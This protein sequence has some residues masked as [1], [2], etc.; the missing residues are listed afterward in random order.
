MM[1]LLITVVTL[2]VIA[3]LVALYFTLLRSLYPE[4]LRATEVVTITTRDV[5]RLRMCRY[6]RG[7]SSGEPILFVHGLG[8]NQHNFTAPVNAS[9][10]DYLVERGY[11]CW[12]LDLRGNRSSHPPFEYTRNDATLDGMLFY[13]LPAAIRHIRRTTGYGKVHYVGHSQGGMLLYAY[14]QLF[15]P[16]FI[17]SGTTLGSAVSMAPIKLRFPRLTQLTARYLAPVFG[18]LLRGGAPLV[19]RFHVTTPLFPINLRN[20]HPGVQTQDLYTM[21]EPPRARILE[22]YIKWARA[23]S[24]KM[25]SG[26]LDVQAGIPSMRF[27]LLA[28]L[29]HRDPIAPVGPGV[30]V[31]S[32]LP[33]ET[34]QILVLSKDNG[35]EE[36]YNHCDIP[37]GKNAPRELFDP[38]LRWLQTHPIQERVSLEEIDADTS[39]YLPPLAHTE[40]ASILSGAS[41]EHVT[42]DEPV[43]HI[44]SVSAP[45]EMEPDPEPM[46]MKVEVVSVEV[47]PPRPANK[48]A[49]RTTKAKSGLK[50]QTDA[51]AVQPQSAKRTAS[52]KKLP[53]KKLAAKPAAKKPAAKVAASAPKPAALKVPVKK[54]KALPAPERV[55]VPPA[56]K[57]ALS[58]AAAQLRNL[59]KLPKAKPAAAKKKP[60]AKGRAR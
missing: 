37:F 33:K 55:E 19:K 10:V 27:P 24:W 36:D 20:L 30:E 15:G 60:A 50:S 54:A 5:W 44:Q 38:I 3:F 40:R 25:N 58:N 34:T 17:A 8:V 45:L 9:I 23:K 29:A 49:R 46:T 51:L 32:Q 59:E 18:G 48:P 7:R 35:C 41:Y 42:Q 53:A 56:T 39:S 4:K 52:P 6:R 1:P 26:T 31:L 47:L 57:K 28:V 22:Q 21:L 43:A 12:T 16:Q 14:I 2:V 13:D 11:D